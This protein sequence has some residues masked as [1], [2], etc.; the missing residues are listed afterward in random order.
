MRATR[1]AGD[2]L[3]YRRSLSHVTTQV[4]AQ[5][6]ANNHEAER[7]AIEAYSG[8]IRFAV[9]VG[10]NGIRDLLEM[11]FADEEAHIDWIEAQRD[12]IEQVGIQNYL[13]AQV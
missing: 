4:R 9:S 10:D 5:R 1:A 8:D 12:P 11:I 2:G 13:A 3:A 7:T 6:H